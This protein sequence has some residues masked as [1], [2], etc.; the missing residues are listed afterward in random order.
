MCILLY[1]KLLWHSCI[2]YI[3]GQLEGGT[4]ALSICAFCYM[5]NL[6]GVVD[7]N[8]SMLDWRR[9]GGVNLK[10]SLVVNLKVPCS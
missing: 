1:M 3:Y 8:R 9:R 7:F 2:Q 4:C 5:L 10:V 6:F